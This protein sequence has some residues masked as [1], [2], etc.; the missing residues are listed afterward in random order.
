ML[1]A[2][3]YRVDAVF[4]DQAVEQVGGVAFPVDG[5]APQPQGHP[6]GFRRG[7]ILE[8]QMRAAARIGDEPAVIPKRHGNDPG[9]PAGLAGQLARQGLHPG[10]DLRIGDVQ[11]EPGAHG[12]A[13]R[14]LPAVRFGGGGH[15]GLC[16]IPARHGQGMF[17]L[18][19][20]DL[21]GSHQHGKIRNPAAAR[22]FEAVLLGQVRA[23]HQIAVRDADAGPVEAHLPKVPLA[24]AFRVEDDDLAIGPGGCLPVRVPGDLGAVELTRRPLD[25]IRTLG[26]AGQVDRIG[27]VG[28][29][30]VEVPR[31]VR[32]VR[33]QASGQ[34]AGL[35]MARQPRHRLVPRRVRAKR[36]D[37]A[38]IEPR[39]AGERNRRA[40]CRSRRCVSNPET[41]RTYGQDGA[42]PAVRKNVPFTHK[43]P[44]LNMGI[45][46]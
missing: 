45:P 21:L 18:A 41:T 23:R 10:I 38:C 28:K 36:T 19:L 2:G 5:L 9:R 11:R 14:S 44:F 15:E 29:G 43:T 3:R 17:D 12:H 39:F 4:R 34:G 6:L 37:I 7:V 40:L 8:L 26:V 42:D 22:G 25:R 35:G 31:P 27:V 13:V 16:G 46:V 20:G 30:Q 32:A 24:P 33:P 1:V